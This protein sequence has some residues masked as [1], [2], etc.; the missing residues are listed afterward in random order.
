MLFTDRKSEWSGIGQR[1]WGV[2][3]IERYQVQKIRDQSLTFKLLQVILQ[4]N[5]LTIANLPSVL[6]KQAMIP[7]ITLPGP[8]AWV[9]FVS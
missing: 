2:V 5:S 4:Y 1:P 6:S 9:A 3:L 7:Q 8:V